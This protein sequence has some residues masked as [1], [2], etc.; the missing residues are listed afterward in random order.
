MAHDLMIEDGKAAMM[1]FGTTPWHGLGQE[2]DK[3]ATAAQAIEAAGLDWPVS[4]ERLFVDANGTNVPVKGKMATSR[5][6]ENGRLVTLGVV[7]ERYE[8]LQN[9]DAFSFFDPI[10]GDG[11]AVF[12]TA[13]ALDEGRRIWV[14]AK[15]PGEIRVVGDDVVDKFLLLSNSHD[16]SRSVRVMFTPIRVVCQNTLSMAESRHPFLSIV[17]RGDLRERLERARRMLRLVNTRYQSIEHDFRTL[18]KVQMTGNLLKEYLDRLFPSP[19]DPGRPALEEQLNLDLRERAK[20]LFECGSG[21]NLLGARGTLWAAY[22]GVTEAVDFRAGMRHNPR[23]HLSSIWY[24]RGREVKVKAL[25]TALEIA[26]R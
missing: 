7:S 25:S 21:N 5:V 3:P 22:N 15:L 14:L 9:R 13:G 2:L 17:H 11:A 24:G 26:Q 8:V 12:H 20:F 6:D 19:R 16:G 4:K 18:V 23:R 1:Y 10:V